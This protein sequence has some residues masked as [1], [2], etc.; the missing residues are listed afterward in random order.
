MK[1]LDLNSQWNEI[2]EDVYGNLDSFFESS[3]YVMGPYLEKFENNFSKWSGRKYS[4]GV[5]N[6]TDGLK[7]A[8]QAF[9][10][11]DTTTDVILPANGYIADV[12]AVESQIKGE[13][14]VSL[15]DHDDYFQID[16]NLLVDH[17]DNT[18]FVNYHHTICKLLENGFKFLLLSLKSPDLG[19]QFSNDSF[20]SCSQLA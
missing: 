14:N 18:S 2:K 16:L 9:E 17:L 10:F 7:L 5:S 8:I 11:Y 15:V 4:V 12:L 3:S 6:G 13:F 1:F 19:L 20:K